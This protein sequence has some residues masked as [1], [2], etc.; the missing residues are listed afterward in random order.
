[1]IEEDLEQL[2]AL[3]LADGEGLPADQV[4][5]ACAPLQ[6]VLTVFQ[7]E[8]GILISNYRQVCAVASPSVSHVLLLGL[9][10]SILFQL[11]GT[12][13]LYFTFTHVKCRSQIS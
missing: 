9:S 1:M 11:S 6:S 2:K 13:H 4:E 8:T 5:E 12:N 3:F 10:L 7:L